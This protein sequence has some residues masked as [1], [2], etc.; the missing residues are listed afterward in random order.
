MN[1]SFSLVIPLEGWDG[2]K[3]TNGTNERTTFSLTNWNFLVCRE[4]HCS[5][6]NS[7]EDVLDEIKISVRWA[8]AF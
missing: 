8:G 6:F 2:L 5:A 7:G 1:Q 3:E 4:L